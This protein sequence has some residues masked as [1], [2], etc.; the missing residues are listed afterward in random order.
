[1]NTE[2]VAKGRRFA[3]RE[4]IKITDVNATA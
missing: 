4:N 2:P 3:K 1:V